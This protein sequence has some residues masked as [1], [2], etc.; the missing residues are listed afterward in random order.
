VL[1]ILRLARR[2]RVAQVQSLVGPS[3]RPASQKIPWAVQQAQEPQPCQITRYD[4]FFD[5][6]FLKKKKN[7]RL[8][9]EWGEAMS[10]ATIKCDVGPNPNFIQVLR[11]TV[12]IFYK[13]I[14]MCRCTAPFYCYSIALCLPLLS[15]LSMARMLETHPPEAFL[16]CLLLPCGILS[17]P[18]F[19]PLCGPHVRDSPSRSLF[20]YFT[21]TLVPPPS[22]SSL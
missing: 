3:R 21:A 20:F 4:H 15:G 12:G 22:S 2:T 10:E 8:P 5:W 1:L 9:K 16:L 17:S 11:H 7:L 6:L 18:P 19:W 13:D 14:Y